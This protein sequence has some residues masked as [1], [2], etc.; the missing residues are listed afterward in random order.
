M[1]IEQ[2]VYGAILNAG[3]RFNDMRIGQSTTL[4]G[5][6]I[7]KHMGSRI[8]QTLTG[9]YD[10][11]GETVI[12]GDTDSVSGDSIIKTTMGEMTIEQLFYYC[13]KKWQINDREFSSSDTI[14]VV[15]YDDKQNIS[16]YDNIQY[17]YRHKVNKQMWEIEDENGN[18][19]KVTEDHSIMVERNG[20]LM[21]IKPNDLLETD[22]L[23]QLMDK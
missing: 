10:L 23:I 5:R 9:E 18:T 4:T 8:N 20:N 16:Y 19:I 14:K 6:C 2:N 17:V 7:T 11:N 12:Y 15:T 22:M 1:S 3:C 21:E 13:N